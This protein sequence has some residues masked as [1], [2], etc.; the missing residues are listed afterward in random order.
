MKGWDRAGIQLA[1]PGSAVRLASYRLLYSAQ[2]LSAC[3]WRIFIVSDKN[4]IISTLLIDN[5]SNSL[6][7][8]LSGL[9]VE[10]MC[11]GAD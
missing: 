10:I 2:Q 1:T 3:I 6:L 4:N 8:V 7:I 11:H 9:A 5:D